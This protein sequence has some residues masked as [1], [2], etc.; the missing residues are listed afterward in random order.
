MNR[1]KLPPRLALAASFVRKGSRL[2]DIGTD[3]AFLPVRLIQEGVISSAIAADVV[4]GPLERA[5]S[6]VSRYGLTKVIDCRLSDGFAAIRPEE[7]DDGV[8]C[9]MGG[10]TILD[11]LKAAHPF[12]PHQRLILQPQTDI[13]L[14]RRWLYENGYELIDEQAV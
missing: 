5:K 9:G 11:I 12:L 3:H 1:I 14:V 7:F 13:H 10:L 6:T 2:A 4:P 8:V